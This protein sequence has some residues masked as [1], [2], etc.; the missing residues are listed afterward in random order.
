[1]IPLRVKVDGFLSY[2]DEAI[3][4]FDG[5][6]LWMLTGANGSGKSAIFDAVTFAL[7]GA[8]RGGKNEAGHLI[9]HERDKFI[10]E[11]DFGLGEDIYRAR[12]TENRRGQV[13]RQIIHLSGP[14]P[15][16][17]STG[18]PTMLPETETKHGFVNWVKQNIGLTYEAFKASTLLHQ[19]DSEALLKADP[20]K[21]HEILMQLIDLSGYVRL[22]E[23]AK[24]KFEEY[25]ARED[26]ST[27]HL[28]QLPIVDDETLIELEK[29]R[30]AHRCTVETAQT[31]LRQLAALQV[32][33]EHWQSG[34]KKLEQLELNLNKIQPLLIQSREIEQ[35]A[36]RWN[37]L[38][39]IVPVLDRLLNART[40]QTHSQRTLK[41]CH[42]TL[43]QLKNEKQQASTDKEKYT[44]ALEAIRAEQLNLNKAYQEQQSQIIELKPAQQTLSRISDLKD[45]VAQLD[46]DLE[47]FP[48]S[49]DGDLQ[50][51]DRTIAELTD[52]KTILADLRQIYTSRQEE[53]Q[54]LKQVEGAQGKKAKLDEQFQLLEQQQAELQKQEREARKAQ[55]KTGTTLARLT[56]D[57]EFAQTR[58]Q[59]LADLGEASICIH[60]GHSLT[61]THRK[62]EHQKLTRA[63]TE[64]K[65]AQKHAQEAN[66]EVETSLAQIIQ[67]IGKLEPRLRHGHSQIATA[68]Q[69]TEEYQRSAR[70]ATRRRQQAIKAL[71]R[72]TQAR[73]KEEEYP[74]AADLQALEAEIGSLSSLRA[75]QSRLN[76]K[77]K[78]RD[79]KR[80]EREPLAKELEKLLAAYPPELNQAVQVQLQTAETSLKALE[81]NLLK[82]QPQF[83]VLNGQ[84]KALD[85]TF[86]SLQAQWS[87]AE[88]KQSAA[89]AQQV[90]A[91]SDEHSEQEA[92]PQIAQELVVQLTETSLQMLKVEQAQLQPLNQ[93]MPQLQ[94]ARQ[95]EVHWRKDYES[96]TSE[97]SEI[98]PEAYYE[99]AHFEDL[100][101]DTQARQQEAEKARDEAE[102]QRLMLENRRTERAQVEAELF[103]SAQMAK[104]Y[105]TLAD[106]LGRDALQRHL[107]EQVE[108]AIIDNANSV[109]DKIS[110]GS[111]WLELLGDEDSSKTKALDLI[112][113]YRANNAVL[114]VDFLSGSQKFRVAVSLALGIGQYA[115]QES[116]KVEAVIVDEGFGSLDKSGRFEMIDELR[117][118]QNSLSRIILVSHQ[119]E[120]AQAFTNRYLVSLHDGNSTVSLEVEY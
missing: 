15:P 7:Y 102:S 20:K 5:A 66:E 73:V 51:L 31:E 101:H 53:S 68:Q 117:N 3:L 107:L 106:L 104:R 47:A 41:E 86:E 40:R 10:V 35:G 59:N 87:D 25:A 18:G 96:I 12:R 26:V 92:L 24:T 111:L 113:H 71:P 98:P 63:V 36:Q 75:R 99:T 21:R 90:L 11:F 45:Q 94:A 1:M 88:R 16:P 14:N 38:A 64:S 28:E 114:P 91:I 37:Y 39:E 43:E 95:D 83:E 32:H 80:A 61:P 120:F 58:L 72:A 46:K 67:A 23:Q 108:Q 6:S 109:L 62:S 79:H 84:L 89:N 4:D 54:A 30:E 116:H 60:C 115:S 22:Y 110:G 97:I 112:A 17:H 81:N 34:K 78:D 2:R 70:E 52:T 119:E 93:A 33:A 74:S 118:L 105:K 55:V 49:L 65:T 82:L 100:I 76:Q 8:H 44:Q 56:A 27:V 42:L 85:K 103:K 77:V 29:T 9:N 13:T 69:T 48:Q 50:K 57:L 19:G